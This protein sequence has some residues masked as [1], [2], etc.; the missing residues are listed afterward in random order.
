[1]T[2]VK[3]PYNY[4]DHAAAAADDD[5]CSEC[6]SEGDQNCQVKEGKALKVIIVLL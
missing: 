4:G 2:T 5:S 3:P 6:S 1:M